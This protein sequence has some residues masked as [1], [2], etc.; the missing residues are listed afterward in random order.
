[1]IDFASAVKAHRSKY[2]GAE[3]LQMEKQ[4][5]ESVQKIT[6]CLKEGKNG[7]FRLGG[8][9]L[10]LYRSQNFAVMGCKYDPIGNIGNCSPTVFFSYLADTF[11]LD[12]S[13]V[14]R[15][16]NVADEFGVS[17]PNG[18]GGEATVCQT[19][20][21][22][23]SYSL[24]VEMLPLTTEQR[25]AVSENW[26]V[27]QLREYRKKLVA[28]SQPEDEAEPEEKPEDEFARFRKWTRPDFCRKIVEL[29]EEN[30]ILR[31][32]LSEAQREN[33]HTA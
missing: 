20:Y 10:E 33:L 14:S 16:M 4:L 23:F 32:A 31:N 22:K 30:E 18:H 29:E 8:Y 25:E 26:T 21:Q 12:K 11:D 6:Q 3:S 17:V 24:L 9:L 27:A 15:V 5:K 19:K 1:M 13:Q 7:K 28:T 2:L